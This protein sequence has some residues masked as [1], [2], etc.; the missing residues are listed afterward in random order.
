M[1]K[2]SLYRVII[3]LKDTGEARKVYESEDKNAAI[4]LAK[5]LAKDLKVYNV[6]VSEFELVFKLIVFTT[7]NKQ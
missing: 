2:D 4:D 5:E 6:V 3:F 7:I 1:L